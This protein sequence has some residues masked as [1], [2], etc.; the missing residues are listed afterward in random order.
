V[1]EHF[2]RRERR[3]VQVR[4]PRAAVGRL[5]KDLTRRSRGACE[6]CGGREEM[7]PCELLPLAD[8]PDLDR[9]VLGC[10][11]CR[12]WLAGLEIDAREARFLAV[13]VWS[14]VPAVHAA[15]AQLLVT[16]DEPWAADALEAVT[17]A[18]EAARAA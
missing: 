12:G 3:K 11:R 4:P 2:S 13:A 9:T 18:A 6:L 17:S 16:I 14:E 8:E 1:K 10:G 7:L 5:G 15:A